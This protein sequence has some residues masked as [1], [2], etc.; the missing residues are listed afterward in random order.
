MWYLK[1]PCLNIWHQVQTCVQL[2]LDSRQVHRVLYY[3]KIVLQE[4]NRHVLQLSNCN[5]CASF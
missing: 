1:I 2:P 5:S 3:L 4:N